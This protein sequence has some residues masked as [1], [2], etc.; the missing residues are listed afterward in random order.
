MRKTTAVAIPSSSTI[1]CQTYK[2]VMV[3]SVFHAFLFIFFIIELTDAIDCPYNETEVDRTGRRCNRDTSSCS[4]ESAKSDC[5]GRRRCKC[6]DI[7][8]FICIKVFKDDYCNIEDLGSLTVGLSV[9]YTREPVRFGTNATFS[10]AP[11]YQLSDESLSMRKCRGDQRWS[12]ETPT[13]VTDVSCG[14]PPAVR[15][16]RHNGRDVYGNDRLIYGIGERLKFT[17]WHGYYRKG[18]SPYITCKRDEF[19]SSVAN[20]TAVDPYLECYPVSCGFPGN[21]A[22]G[23]R[24]GNVFTFGSQVTFECNTGYQLSGRY[25]RTCQ[26]NQQWDGY[27]PSCN[28]I[29]CPRISTPENGGLFGSSTT[30]R[31]SVAIECEDGFVVAGTDSQL[32]TVTCQADKTWTH[33]LLTCEAVDCG[34][35]GIPMN[36]SRNGVNFGYN[37]YIIFSCDDGFRLEGSKSIYC[38]GNNKW[39]DPTPIC[40]GQC[41]LPELADNL[42]PISGY[43]PGDKVDEGSTYIITCYEGYNLNSATNI[44][45]CLA[46]GKMSFV[47][48]CIEDPCPELQNIDNGR[49]EYMPTDAQGGFYMPGTIATYYCDEG[50][51]LTKDYQ[52]RTCVRGSFTRESPTCTITTCDVP[53][54]LNGNVVG[55]FPGAVNHGVMVNYTCDEGYHWEGSPLLCWNKTFTPTH[56]LCLEDPCSMVSEISNGVVEYDTMEDGNGMFLPGTSV[57]YQCLEGYKLSDESLQIRN[58]RKGIFS[59]RSPACLL[60]KCDIPITSNGKV[61]ASTVYHGM[62]VNFTCHFGYET[63][64]EFTAILCWNEMLTPPVPKCTEKPCQVIPRNISI[65]YDKDENADGTFPP[66]TRA[67]WQTT[68]IGLKTSRICKM[69]STCHLGLFDIKTE[70]ITTCPHYEVANAVVLYS[71]NEIHVEPTSILHGVQRDVICRNPFVMVNVDLRK[72]Y[73]QNNSQWSKRTPSCIN[74]CVTLPPPMNGSHTSDTQVGSKITYQTV[75]TTCSPKYMLIGE[76]MNKCKSTVVQ[77][78][79]CLAESEYQD[80]RYC[81]LLNNKEFGW[82]TYS[83]SLREGSIVRFACTH[84]YVSTISTFSRECRKME[85]SS[86]GY[87]WFPRIE[88]EPECNEPNRKC[89]NKILYEENMGSISASSFLEKEPAYSLSNAVDWRPNR[90]NDK[91][92]WLQ[93]QYNNI[94]TL[95]GVVLKSSKRAWV[96]SYHVKYRKEMEKGSW[97]VVQNDLGRDMKFVGNINRRMA[98]V[99]AFPHEIKAVA[100][101]VYPLEWFSSI[102]MRIGVFDCQIK[103]LDATSTTVS[104]AYESTTSEPTSST[105]NRFDRSTTLEPTSSTESRFDHATSTTVSSAYEST[106]LE[107]TSSTEIR[108][109]RSTTSEPTS[110]TESRFVHATSTKVSSAYDIPLVTMMIEVTEI[111]EGTEGRGYK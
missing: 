25:Y 108:F 11:G 40:K 91:K 34:N 93:I 41:E 19:N 56:P 65:N 82:Y 16:A 90:K 39:S 50:Y 45:K 99:Q 97:N 28:P 102:N 17:C 109:D 80:G 106:I 88:V 94:Q 104:S 86:A 62:L 71:K 74:V 87:D 4:G 69:N 10:C 70:C 107:P 21:I 6:D 54:I 111:I 59:G 77:Q 29:Q 92:P 98:V 42:T 26:A 105:E 83:D 23:K 38:Q 24:I 37:G 100:L 95:Y 55:S 2:G 44:W 22:N 47:P 58:C 14:P 43:Y 49:I 46:S 33:S 20:W 18:G 96:T 85:N 60:T 36:G 76:P 72:S 8:G 75:I 7:C 78:P 73:C 35:P 57:T 5:K 101:R 84:G 48:V 53:A 89:L 64:N 66:G 31:S 12:G 81:P 68:E 79:Q 3:S 103:I 32:L 9:S 63:E 15:R 110:S 51:E 30:Y 52:Q 27:V 61:N 67:L 13:C 1:P